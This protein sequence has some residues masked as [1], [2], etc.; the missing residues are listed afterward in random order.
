MIPNRRAVIEMTSGLV[1]INNNGAITGDAQSSDG[2]IVHG[3][4]RSPEGMITLFVPPF[5]SANS[6]TP[7]GINDEGVITGSCGAG[8]HTVGWVRFP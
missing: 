4:V 7:G 6:T 1:S 2:S 5:C 3:Y 8:G